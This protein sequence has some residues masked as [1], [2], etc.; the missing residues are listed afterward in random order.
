[1]TKTKNL[2]YCGIFL[3]L[4]SITIV[5]CQTTKTTSNSEITKNELKGNDFKNY[6]YLLSE[7]I[8]Q[9]VIGNYGQAII[10]FKQCL[11]I[12]PSSDAAM[13]EL[14]SIYVYAR[15]YP[16]ALK[17]ARMAAL[18]DDDNLW[19]KLQLAG[20]YSTLEVYDSS[21][22]VYESITA[23]HPEKLDLMFQLGNMYSEERLYDKAINVYDK[24]EKSVGFQESL[25]IARVDIYRQS[26][27]HKRAE[28]ELY[29]VLEV[30]PEN[31]SY[32]ILSAELLYEQGEKDK[33]I[34]KYDELLNNFPDKDQVNMS[35]IRFHMVNKEYD[36]MMRVVDS[37]ILGDNSGMEI[38]F[39]LVVSLISDEELFP[40]IKNK[41]DT[42]L[43]VLQKQYAEDIR[44]LALLGDFYVKTGE[45]KLAAKY[46]K[47]YIDFD[48]RNYLVWE[49]LLFLLNILE[50]TEDLYVYS[51]NALKLFTE[52]P[53]LY[54]FN[55]LACTEKGN[56]KATINVLLKG[57]GFV[58]DN[59][60][61]LV[62]FYSLLGEAY[63][64]NGQFENSNQSFEDALRIDPGNLIVLNNYSYYLS[65][66]G[67]NLKKALEMSKIC[68][69]SEP[70]NG[71]YLDTYGWVLF[72]MKKYSYAEKYL[73]KAIE[74]ETNPSEEV[75]KHYGDVNEKL[76]R[77]DI[78]VE[79]WKKAMEA[80]GD[81]QEL[82]KKINN[83]NKEK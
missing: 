62:Q 59:N 77:F 27:E 34:R 78:A 8:K 22:L 36:N 64:N 48:N 14:S 79:Y 31:L 67:E 10:Y 74:N 41:L 30:A 29:R 15:D 52:A 33:A 68:I 21:I 35:I 32:Q 40:N 37:V 82:M 72:S 73:R 39:N 44:I 60:A 46:F 65:L 47:E 49:Q 42:S 81:K 55:G 53:I 18:T 38:K 25:S 20:L 5:S 57:L 9:K 50:E 56:N 3:I 51:S 45:Y 24:L 1:M 43:I 26:G 17:Y 66:R 13:F 76:R 6:N 83:V 16:L 23:K 19:Y 71:T 63:K 7:A 54:F 69:E 70:T 4:A 61:L 28:N 2:H 12:N 80:G 58:E 75:L 11:D